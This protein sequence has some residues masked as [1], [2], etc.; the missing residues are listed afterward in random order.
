VE[1]FLDLRQYGFGHAPGP[2]MVVN[3]RF[4]DRGSRQIQPL[5]ELFLQEAKERGEKLV[6]F[7]RG[8]KS[9]Q[10]VQAVVDNLGNLPLPP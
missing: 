7:I 9:A 2:Q 1:Q 6:R 10:L 5:T 8:G 4:S 3:D